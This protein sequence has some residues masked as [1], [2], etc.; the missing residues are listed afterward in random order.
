MAL[1]LELGLTLHVVVLPCTDPGTDPGTDP[2]PTLHLVP[3]AALHRPY[4]DP[5]P[6]LVPVAA[7]HRPYTDPGT[8]L[9]T[10]CCLTPALVPVAALHRPWYRLLPYNDPGTGCCCAMDIQPRP[11]SGLTWATRLGGTMFCE[12]CGLV[13]APARSSLV[14]F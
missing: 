3:V 10:G 6:T 11:R 9:G 14:L 7:L 1:M 4:T 8:D 5:T 2:T 13:H 12:S